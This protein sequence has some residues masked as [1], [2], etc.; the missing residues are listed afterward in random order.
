MPK[1]FITIDN[2]FPSF[3]GNESVETKVNQLY[4]YTFMLLE[5]LRYL[6]RNLDT[7][8]FNETA[9]KNFRKEYSDEV[10]HAISDFEILANENYASASLFSEFQ[11]ET[12]GKFS[13][14][15]NALSKFKTEVSDTYAK[16]SMLA[17]YDAIKTISDGVA[18]NRESISGVKA[19]A[20]QNGSAIENFASWKK[21][22]Y[23]DDNSEYRET[24]AGIRQSAADAESKIEQFTEWK[25]SNF[26]TFEEGL[27][28]AQT[29]AEATAAE[30][31]AE[32]LSGAN[33]YTDGEIAAVT[34]R[35]T[36]VESSVNEVKEANKDFAKSS[37]LTEY[38]RTV[39]EK[40]TA[41]DT[42][43][44]GYASDAQTAA[45]ATAVE[46][47]AEALS[48][49]NGYT[50][51]K[52]TT[53]TERL[54]SVESSVNEVKEANKDFAKSSE[55]TEYKRT[56]EEKFTAADKTAK[57][58]ASDAQTAAEATA[59]EKAAEALSGANG[60]T[61]GEIA[62]VTE[63]LTSVESSVN[64]VKEA[65]KDFAK[66]SELT[67]YKRTVE[68]KFT[69]ADT[70]AKGYASDAQTAAEATAV[71]KAAEALSGAN[72]YTDGKITT[73]TESIAAVEKQAGINGAFIKMMV[74]N[75]TIQMIDGKLK[76]ESGNAISSESAAEFVMEAANGESQ[77]KLK[78]DKIAFGNDAGVYGDGNLYLS[79]LFGKSNVQSGNYPGQFYIEVDSDFDSGAGTFGGDLFMKQVSSVQSGGGVPQSGGAALYGF[80]YGN[81]VENG[82]TNEGVSVNFTVGR[83]ENGAGSDSKKYLWGYNYKE[84]KFYAKGTW[85]FS[86]AAVTG[87]ADNL[88]GLA[89]YFS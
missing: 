63:R 72:G 13:E 6:F 55:L 23:D 83:R 41:A 19:T 2:G 89:V 61:D 27:K 36:S 26:E 28:A 56:V 5:S 47:A 39:E 68:E 20:D 86:S 79:K 51:G 78:A 62:A 14:Q 35:L 44:K 40:F 3:T 31:A 74:G 81:S 77:I 30:K 22:F 4:N 29:A 84:D 32:A 70:A 76:D 73:V 75:K 64:E 21:S 59:A 48:G 82:V 1:D 34:E 43:A 38:K 53:V 18:E 37:E 50:D 58:Y 67:E 9:L 57:G 85:D 42:A 17:E 49:A 52:I 12:D 69:A 7:D 15:T 10:A 16:T 87:L 25:G 8:N 88:T 66:S 71:E 45:E 54:T 24:I 80:E 46:K 65:N 33:G 60:Y 11:T